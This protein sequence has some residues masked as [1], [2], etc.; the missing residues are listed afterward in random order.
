MQT[1]A[2]Q[3]LAFIQ[4]KTV[5]W[6]S[7]T[8]GFLFSGYWLVRD[9]NQEQARVIARY[10]TQIQHSQAYAIAAASRHN[11]GLAKQFITQLMSDDSILAAT[12]TD[13]SAQLL[14]HH[15][16]PHAFAPPLYLWL[17]KQIFPDSSEL[18]FPLNNAETPVG[19]LTITVC[20][21]TAA[22]QFVERNVGLLLKDFLHTMLLAFTLL[23]LFYW[24]LS[25]PI[26]LLD[27]WVTTHQKKRTPMPLLLRDRRDELGRLAFS[28]DALCRAR[29][30]AESRL[31]ALAYYDSLTGLANRSRLLQ[32]LDERLE[33]LNEAGALLH[34]D[35]DRFKTINDSL[36]HPIGDELMRVIAYRINRWLT[37]SNVCARIGG[38]E[39][40]VLLHRVTLAQAK[41]HAQTLLDLISQ[42]YSID[43]HQLYCSVSIGIAAFSPQAPS[44]SIDLLRQA[45]TALNRAKLAGKN[46]FASYEQSM[47]TQV[48]TF[49]ETEKGLHLALAEHQLELYFQTQVNEA[50]QLVGMEALVRWHHPERGLLGPDQ[51]MPIAEETG[52]ILTIGQWIVERA[53]QQMARWLDM[54]ILPSSFQR[55]AINISPLQFNHRKFVD[56]FQEAL[57]K[58]HLDG[59]WI[60]LEITENLL[61]ENVSNAARKMRQLKQFGVSLAIDD[62]GTGYS[63]LRYLKHLDLDVL[64]VDRSFVTGLHLNDSDQAIVDSIITT[65]KRLNLEIVAEG[66]EDILEMKALTQMG[67]ERFQGFLFD[68][69]QPVEFINQQL[70]SGKGHRHQDEPAMTHW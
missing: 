21:V 67:C 41:T 31:N 58:A 8:I 40:A 61:L 70:R 4:A 60:E 16:R 63:S 11:E 13:D 56:Q 43:N 10:Q 14:A 36:G 12:L 44:A 19:E 26:A 1:T 55:L 9:L 52:Q 28:F 51:F 57:N 35:I 30:T 48:D 59:R 33:P 69:P 17:S 64:K 32:L 5:F 7:I 6:L 54:D 53:C 18:K 62:F 22:K 29:Q 15:K 42:P 20:A 38:D 46:C 39:F 45:D 65:A 66:V 27:S 50:F 23:G 68:T 3:S 37:D 25:R 49:L 47:Q 2:S 34:L 24:R